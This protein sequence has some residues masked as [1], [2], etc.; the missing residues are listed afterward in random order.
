MM[1]PSTFLVGTIFEFFLVFV[2][3]IQENM[4]ARFTQLRVSAVKN[5]YS[6]AILICMQVPIN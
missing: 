1:Y 2:D 3:F 5:D 4:T 6:I